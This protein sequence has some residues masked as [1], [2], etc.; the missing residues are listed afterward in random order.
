[1]PGGF[2]EKEL[3]SSPPYTSELVRGLSTLTDRIKLS[4]LI[5]NEPVKNLAVTRATITNTGR[6]AISKSDI[7]IPFSL[8]VEKPWKI[9]AIVN[10]RGTDNPFSARNIRYL[11]KD[12]R[13]AI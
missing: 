3:R 6:V 9:L 4:V 7:D 12:N 2:T 13:S 5:D 11:D 8:Q 10:F 1:M